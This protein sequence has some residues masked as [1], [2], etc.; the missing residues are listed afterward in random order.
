M[1][2][3]LERSL[4]LAVGG[5]WLLLGTAMFAEGTDNFA[6]VSL[7]KGVSIEIP[8]NWI[9][10]ANNQRITLDTAV[11]SVL[12]LS[13]INQ[14]TSEFPFAANYYDNRGTT[15]G[16]LN[17]RYYPELGASQIDAVG[18]TKSDVQELDIVLKEN[19]LNGAKALDLSIIS[20]SGTVKTEINGITAFV[21]E[22]SRASRRVSGDFQVKLVRVPAGNR[23]FTLTVSYLNSESRVMRPIID[24]II[25]TVKVKEVGTFP[26]STLHAQVTE[27]AGSQTVMTQIYGEHWGLVLL[28]SALITWGVGLTPPI[29][30]RLVFMRRPISKEWAIGVVALLWIFNL[31]LF[32]ALE[33]QSKSHGA[34]ALVA[35][36]SYAILRK[37]SKNLKTTS[38]SNKQQ[39]TLSKENIN[40]EDK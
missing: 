37:G 15:I 16:I 7:P 27:K 40:A 19:I 36:A 4:V 32:T 9:V 14:Q 26:N 23:S 10:L 2:I 20:W 6:T 31:L 21:T 28:L 12:D 5:F 13:G 30:I 34:L 39:P 8:Q 29:L 18:A 17:I 33:S 25:S 24:R 3:L 22:Y 38:D 1:K 11:E 35:F